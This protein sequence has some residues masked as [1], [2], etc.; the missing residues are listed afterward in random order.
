MASKV[1]D[2][3]TRVEA[4]LMEVKMDKVVNLDVEYTATTATKDHTTQ[5]AALIQ[6]CL[7]TDCLLY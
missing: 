1:A 2:F 7:G 5:K 6:L 4:R 3:L